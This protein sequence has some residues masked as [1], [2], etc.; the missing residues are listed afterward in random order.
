MRIGINFELTPTDR[1][2][3]L[4]IS[5]DRNSPQKHVWRAKIVLL[6]ADGVG[7]AE[8]HASNRSRQDG[9]VALARALHKRGRGS[10]AARQDP[11]VPH[12]AI[13]AGEGGVGGHPHP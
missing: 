12:I 1:E 10:A 6:S 3:L 9:R 13:A 11:A 4:A 8:I 2:Q 7:T 5:A